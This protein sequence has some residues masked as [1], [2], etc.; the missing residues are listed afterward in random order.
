[1][2]ERPVYAKSMCCIPGCPR[3]SRRFPREW[4]CAG[5]WRLLPRTWR[6]ILRRTWSRESA[7]IDL[8]R[9]NGDR[10]SYVAALRAIHAER[11]LW[12]RAKRF[13]ILHE[14]GL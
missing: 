14:A 6:V 2:A 13:L 12:G 5:H 7:W 10:H 3:W 11:R 8:N 9:A 1:M 4:L